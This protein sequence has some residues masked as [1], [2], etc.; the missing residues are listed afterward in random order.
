MKSSQGSTELPYLG[1]PS[2]AASAFFIVHYPHRKMSKNKAP[3]RLN[4]PILPLLDG[5]SSGY[6][7]E[8]SFFCAEPLFPLTTLH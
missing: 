4:G 7:Q 3:E 6:I 1:T 8:N 5:N 2:R